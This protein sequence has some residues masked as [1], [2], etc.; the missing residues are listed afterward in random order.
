MQS[1]HILCANYGA[2]PALFLQIQSVILQIQ[3][4]ILQ[5]QS[6]ILQI[7]S[8]IL[9]IKSVILRIKNMYNAVHFNSLQFPVL[10]E[11]GYWLPSFHGV[12]IQSNP[13]C[14]NQG[15]Q[16]AIG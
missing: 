16:Q 2:N 5:I 13:P 15:G 9:Q 14:Y 1:D 7:Q 6:V 11:G 8:A 10:A 12:E 3:S 4:V